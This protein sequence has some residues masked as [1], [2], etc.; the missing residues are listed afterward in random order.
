MFG[1]THHVAKLNKPSREAKLDQV[2][3]QWI[4]SC[5][6][7]LSSR[8]C[9][10][11]VCPTVT[12][13]SPSRARRPLSRA[14]PPLASWM[15]WLVVWVQD[16]TVWAWRT[17]RAAPLFPEWAGSCPPWPEALSWTSTACWAAWTAWS[18]PLRKTHLSRRSPPYGL[19]LRPSTHRHWRK[20][21]SLPRAPARECRAATGKLVRGFGRFVMAVWFRPSCL[22]QLV[23][24]V[25]ATEAASSWASAAAPA[26][27]G[28]TELHSCKDA[29]TQSH[30]QIFFCIVTLAC[31]LT[32]H[33]QQADQWLVN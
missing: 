3:R 19:N 32:A 8:S 6:D 13:P 2:R 12:L 33:F 31:R 21:S 4:L 30:V 1:R 17:R 26:V 14:P 24:V 23:P 28:L 11:V 18:S 27:H 29:P 5:T 15:A 22:L 16:Q 20:A 7:F 25:R 10:L 9:F